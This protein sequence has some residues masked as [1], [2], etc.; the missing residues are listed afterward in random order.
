MW[1]AG[2]L[3]EPASSETLGDDAAAPSRYSEDRVAELLAGCRT[4]SR[5]RA[6]EALELPVRAAH[7]IIESNYYPTRFAHRPNPYAEAHERRR[8]LDLPF[9]AD[10]F[11]GVVF[12]DDL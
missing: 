8:S 7:S 3:P 5:R 10:C 1:R 11:D 6:L 2:E 12:A 4:E 9:P